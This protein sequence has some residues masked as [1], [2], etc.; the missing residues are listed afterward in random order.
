VST[1]L[2]TTMAFDVYARAAR[3]L[4]SCEVTFDDNKPHIEDTAR[5]RAGFRHAEGRDTILDE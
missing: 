4:E 2:R 5:F 1:F 3:D